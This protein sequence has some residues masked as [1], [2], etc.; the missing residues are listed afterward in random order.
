[1]LPIK[2][3]AATKN[4]LLEVDFLVIVYSGEQLFLTEV[5]CRML[6]I[7]F[8]VKKF[9]LSVE[10]TTISNNKAMS[11]FCSNNQALENHRFDAGID[12]VTLCVKW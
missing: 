3:C 2:L 11:D 6:K 8:K 9:G 10:T 7:L 4:R 12:F 5:C 1:M